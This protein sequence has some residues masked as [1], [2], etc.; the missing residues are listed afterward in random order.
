MIGEEQCAGRDEAAG[1][2]TERAL[3]LTSKERAAEND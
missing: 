1:R 3:L 2:G